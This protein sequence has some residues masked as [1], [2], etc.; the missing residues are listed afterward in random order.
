MATTYDTTS[1]HP[2]NGCNVLFWCFNYRIRNYTFISW[3]WRQRVPPRNGNYLSYILQIYTLTTEA[4]YSS[5][6]LV[7]TYKTTIISGGGTKSTRYCGHFWPIV[8]A[9]D[10]RWGWLWSNYF[11]PEGVCRRILWKMVTNILVHISTLKMGVIRFSE[12]LKITN[13]TTQCLNP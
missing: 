5:E 2:D 10:D 4:I 8:Q 1:F 13:E 11:Y 9:P 6:T 3:R 12:T 7:T